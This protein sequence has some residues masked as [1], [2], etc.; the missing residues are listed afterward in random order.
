M[1]PR[2]I[3]RIDQ[4]YLLNEQRKRYKQFSLH[5]CTE[6]KEEVLESDLSTSESLC[7]FTHRKTASKYWL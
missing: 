6:S 3:Y 2:I 7:K 1:A 4:M 5:L